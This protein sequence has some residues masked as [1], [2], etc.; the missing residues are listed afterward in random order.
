MKIVVR[1]Y[2]EGACISYTVVR[3]NINT[4]MAE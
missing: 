2:K 4:E 3:S 1:R